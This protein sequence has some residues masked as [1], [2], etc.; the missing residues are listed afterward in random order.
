MIDLA[1]EIN[2]FGQIRQVILDSQLPRSLQLSLCVA[3]EE[4]YLN[5][6]SYAFK[7]VIGEEEPRIRFI[8]EYSDR[9]I[10]RFEDNGM[11]YDPTIQVDYDID[12]D[13][14]NQLGGLGKIIA[15]TIADDVRYEYRN[16]QNVLTLVKLM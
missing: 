3:A 11:P 8:F 14:D 13:P 4:I 2:A 12:Y 1:P 5:I 10:M 16:N 9:V 7:G 15:F 6:C